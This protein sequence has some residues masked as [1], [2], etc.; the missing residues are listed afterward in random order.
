MATLTPAAPN[1]VRILPVIARDDQ[2]SLADL[3][4]PSVVDLALVRADRLD[5][6]RANGQLAGREGELRYVAR[7]FD[8]AMHL[9]AGADVTDL[10]QLAGRKVALGA[11]GSADRFSAERIL[12]RLGVEVV[13]VD[14]GAIAAIERLRRGDIAAVALFGSAPDPRLARLAS[15]GSRLHLVGVT[16]D[17]RLGEA[18]LPAAV[19]ADAYP[20]L[21]RSGERIET[22]SV[23]EILVTAQPGAGDARAARLAGFVDSFFSR[24]PDIQR[25]SRN[26]A[27]RD[28]NL[29]ARASGWTRLAAAQDW[30]DGKR[31]DA[32]RLA[33]APASAAPQAATTQSSA[34]RPQA[35]ART[36]A[37]PDDE[38]ERFKRFV[39]RKRGKSGERLAT[40]D[41]VVMFE[42][43]QKWRVA[44]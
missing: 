14:D 39:A 25:Q 34:P 36:Q 23:G 38:F 29:S 28:V 10:R 2:Q 9:L 16:W 44:Q 40:D 4:S 3:L 6:V 12:A 43:F 33:Y 42:Q 24:L 30:L 5:D 21:M 26:P 13:A 31:G 11:P 22:I 35:S 19:Q 37:L 17:A 27:W 15:D 18:Y 1:G 41:T 20:N 7:L 32:L 8:P